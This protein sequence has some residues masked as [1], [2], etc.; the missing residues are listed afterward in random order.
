MADFHGSARSNYFRVKDEAGFRQWVATRGLE[1]WEKGSV[2][3]EPRFFAIAP[4]RDSDNGMFPEWD[5]DEA[6]DEWHEV[7]FAAEV[8]DHL[9]EGSVAILMMVGSEK[10][11]YLRGCAW[12]IRAGGGVLRMDLDEIYGLVEKEWNVP[13]EEVTPCSY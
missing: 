4:A 12:A 5:Y 9:A 1:V 13:R 11:R 3:Q 10:L 8:A 2:G 6:E 7:D